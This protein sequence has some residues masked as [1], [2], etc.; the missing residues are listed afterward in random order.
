MYFHGK[1]VIF[2]CFHRSS[3]L[4]I[5]NHWDCR[6]DRINM[7]AVQGRLISRP[8]PVSRCSRAS[9]GDNLQPTASCVILS[10]ADQMRLAV[11]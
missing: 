10:L 9:Y 2:D 4:R 5:G 6:I 11:T 7:A 1:E 8:N 3:D